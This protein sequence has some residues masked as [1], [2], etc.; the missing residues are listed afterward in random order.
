MS[1]APPKVS[2]RLRDETARREATAFLGLTTDDGSDWWR[3]WNR[4]LEAFMPGLRL[5]FAPDPCPVDATAIG[6]RPGRFG[7]LF[8]SVMGS[9]RSVSSFAGPN[10]ELVEP[11]SWVF[12]WLRENDWQN[13]DVLRDRKR[14]QEAAERAK[15]KREQDDHDRMTADILERYLAGSRAFVSMNRDSPWTQSHAGRRGAGR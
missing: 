8:P 15:A 7:L 10:D 5:C 12:D 4:D 1:F 9:P 6:A 13:P 14:A 3:G 11:G 2:H